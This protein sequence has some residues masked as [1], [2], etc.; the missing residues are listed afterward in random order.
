[1]HSG[2]CAIV[3]RPNVGKSTLLNAFVGEKLASTSPVPQTTRHVIRGILNRPNAQVVFTD[4]PGIHKP[5]TLLGRRLNDL[6]RA[7]LSAVDC[8]VFVVDGSEGI[9]RGDAFLVT[10]LANVATPVIAVLNKVDLRARSR[11]LPQLVRLAAL[12]DW[13]EVVPISA[14]TGENVD[15]LAEL[16]VAQLPEGPAYF[17]LD[18]VTDQTIEQR[19]AEIVREKAITV[20]REELPHSI[21]VVVDELAPAKP[22]RA[23]VVTTIITASVYVERDSQKG[24][25]IGKGGRVLRDIG[26]H[27]REELEPLLGTPVHLDL[28]VK[29]ARQWQRD[30]RALQRLGY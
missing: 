9:S 18:Q 6:A 11:Q 25:V 19:V 22:G 30:P 7:S 15:V 29:L 26:V 4:T 23:K 5:K 10:L 13:I 2:F 1:M 28:S 21:A 12:G 3:G 24:I 17:P 8:I 20:M 27:A 14:A 16:I